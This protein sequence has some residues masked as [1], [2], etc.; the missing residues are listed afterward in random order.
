VVGLRLNAFAFL[1]LLIHFIAS[2]YYV[3]RLERAAE[4]RTEERDL[5]G[6]ALHV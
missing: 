1:F 2:R 5:S 4:M 3:A 6:S